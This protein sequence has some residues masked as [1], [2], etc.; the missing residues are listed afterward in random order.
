MAQNVRYEGFRSWRALVEHLEAQAEKEGDA[1]ARAQLLL[2]MGSL[3]EFR[4]GEPSEANRSYKEAYRADKQCFAALRGARRLL[5]LRGRIDEKLVQLFEIEFKAIKKAG[6]SA[7]GPDQQGAETNLEFGWVNLVAGADT[8]AI[9]AFKQA[10]YLAPQDP[11][12]QT[13][14]EELGDDIDAPGRVTELRTKSVTLEATDRRAAARATLRAA[15][16]AVRA[17][18]PA[19]Q[20][21]GD[22]LRAAALD[23]EDDTALLVLHARVLPEAPTPAQVEKLYREVIDRATDPATKGRLAHDLAYRMLAQVDDPGTAVPLHEVAFELAPDDERTFEFLLL[24]YKAR[25]E[26][27]RVRDISA[28][29]AAAAAEADAKAYYLSTGAI[30]LAKDMGETALAGALA[31][32]L[33]EIDHAHP[34]LAELTAAGVVA[35]K[36]TPIAAPPA[37]A[38]AAPAPTPVPVAAAPTPAPAPAPAV[39]A[40]THADPAPPADPPAAEEVLDLDLPAP[41]AA[42]ADEAAGLEATNADKALASWRKLLDVAP[43]SRTVLEGVRRVCRA[44]RRWNYLVDAFKKTV[45][46][47]PAGDV[48]ERV[49]LLFELADTYAEDMGQKPSAL[50]P[51]QQAVQLAPKNVD[52]IDRLLALFEA[53]NRPA[54]HVKLLVTKAEALDDPVSKVEVL[55]QVARLYQDKFR[56]VGEAIKAFQH[57]LEV[58]GTNDV[59]ITTLK[60][61]YE[62]RKD[63]ESYVNLAR[64]EIELTDD[65]LARLERTIALAGLA[66]EKIRKPEVCIGLWEQVRGYDPANTDA[67][68]ALVGLY[69]RGKDYAKLAD[70]LRLQVDSVTAPAARK[71]VLLKL[72]LLYGDKIPD[73]G[74][75]IA[76]WRQIME[77]DPSD[78]RAPEQIKKRYL[79]LHAWDDIEAFYAETGGRW[80][81]LIRLLEKDA[82]ASTLPKEEKVAVQMKMAT[83]WLDKLQKADRAAACYEEVLKLEPTHRAAAQALI[84]LYEQLKNAAALARVLEIELGH[85]EDPTE[86]YGTMVR[87]GGL[88]AETLQKALDAFAWYAKAFQL[89]PT[90]PEL[91]DAL[92]AVA[93]KANKVEELVKLYREALKGGRITDELGMR[94]RTARLIDEALGRPEEALKDWEEVLAGD[95]TNADAL[96]AIERLYTQM[97]RFQDL[98]AILEKRRS[99]AASAEEENQILVHIARVWEEALNNRDQAIAVYR[100]VLDARGDDPEILRALQRLYED[101]QKWA[102]LLDMVERQRLLAPAGSEEQRGLAFRVAQ[103]CQTRLSDLGRAVEGY[104]A[105]LEEDPNYQ[106]AVEALEPA[107]EDPEHRAEVAQLLAGLFEKRE[108]WENLVRVT[109][110]LV[111]VADSA[112]EKLGHLR[113]IAE[114]QVQRLAQPERA[115]ATHQRAVRLAPEDVQ[116]LA[117]LEQ[118]AT[119][120]DAWTVMVKLLVEVVEKVEEREVRLRLWLKVAGVRE[121]FLGDGAGAIAA[122]QKALEAESAA[123]E[124]LDALERLFEAAERHED[125]L[126]IYRRRVGVETDPAR[127]EHYFSQMAF[128]SDEILNRPEDAITCYRDILAFD[129]SNRKALR[130]LEALYRRLEKWAELAD[131]YGQLLEQAADAD[132]TVHLKLA[133]AELRH[134]Q[135]KEVDVAIDLYRDILVAD[136]RQAEA[137]RALENILRLPEFELTVART[138]EPVYREIQ[139]WPKL[140]ASLE[141]LV[142]HAGEAREK[143]ELLHQVAQLQEVPGDNPERALDAFV[144]ALHEDPA[145]EATLG[146]IERLARVLGQPGKLVEAIEAEVGHVEDLDLAVRLHAKAAETAERELSDLDRGVKH[147]RAV[148][149]KDPTNMPALISLERIYAA[150]EKYEDL[151]QVFLRK[152]EV[153]QDPA[154]VKEQFVQAGRIYEEILDRKDRAIAVYRQLHEYDGEDLPAIDKLIELYLAQQSWNDLLALYEKKS[155]LVQ[156]LEEKKRILLETGSVLRLEVK[157]RQRAIDT[158][159]RILELDPADLQAIAQ[160]DELYEEAEA[161]HELL[162]VLER[163]AD[164]ATDPNDVLAFRFRAGR[165]WEQKLTEVPKAIEFYRGILDASPDHVPSIEA[166]E[167]LMTSGKEPLAAAAVLGPLYESAGEWRKL[168]ATH[169]VEIAKAEDPFRQVELLHR[170]AELYERPDKLNE[171]ENAF[172]AF[173]KAFRID[174]MNEH[175]L[176]AVERLASMLDVWPRLAT[177]YDEGVT[178]AKE[179]EIKVALGL[180]AAR[181][182]EEEVGAP[183]QAI[184]RMRAV[185]EHDAENPTALRGLDR[186]YR[187]TSAWADLVGVLKREEG[188]AENEDEALLFK[189]DRGQVLQ[190]EL[191]DV[192]GSIEAYREILDINPQHS[193][194]RASLE[195]L[196]AEGAQ[197][198]EIAGIL[199]PIYQAGE[200]WERLAK[201]LEAKVDLYEEPGKKLEVIHRI[202]EI[203]ESRLGNIEGAF[204]WLGRGLQL[205]PEDDRTAEELD[206]LAPILPQGWEELARTYAQ[207]LT[208]VEAGD[209]KLRAGKKLAHISEEQIGDAERTQQVWEHLLE[210]DGSDPEVLSALDRIYQ[211]TMSWEK[212]SEVLRRRVEVESSQDEQ[213]ELLTRLG[214]LHLGDLGD[215]KGAEQ[216]FRRIIDKLGVAHLPALE[217]LEQIYG[218]TGEWPKLYAVYKKQID[219]VLGEA[220]QSEVYAKMAHL[221]ADALEQPQEAVKLWQK[222][223]DI[224]GEE[225]EPLRAL[226]TLHEQ[227]E[228]WQELDAT[229]ERLVNIAAED[230]ERAALYVKIGEIRHDRLNKGS[231]A[232]DAY[233]Q[234]LDIDPNNL[235]ALRRKAAI[236]AERE[237]W[238]DLIETLQ[239]LVDVGAGQLDAEELTEIHAQMGTVFADK[240]ERTFEAIESWRHVLEVAPREPRALDRLEA[241]LKKEERWQEVVEVLE[242][243]VELLAEPADQVALW[244]EVADLWKEKIGERGGSAAGLEA[245]LALQP[246]DEAT[247]TELEAVYGDYERWD[248][249]VAIYGRK[250]QQLEGNSKLRAIVLTKIGRIYLD[251]KH[252]ETSAYGVYKAAYL[253]DFNN[254]EIAQDLERVANAANGW[255][256]LL[257]TLSAKIQELGPTRPAI[258]L[259]LAVGRWYARQL[260]RLDFAVQIY[261]TVL[262]K[263]DPAN[264]DALLFLADAYRDMKQWP[265]L[266]QTLNRCIEVVDDPQRKKNILVQLGQTQEEV[267]GEEREAMM[268]YR[269]A[270]DIDADLPAALEAL[271]R[272]YRKAERWEDLVPILERRIGIEQDG[273]QIVALKLQV[274]ELFE[275]RLQ[276]DEL[277]I[278]AYRDVLDREASNERALKGLERLYAR[279]ERWQDLLD[280]LEIEH[281]VAESERERLTLLERMASMLEEEFLRHEDAAK[282]LEQVLE[283]DPTSENGL[284]GLER[285]YRQLQRWDQLAETYGRHVEAAVERSLKVQH[286]KSQATV[287]LENLNDPDRAIEAL[288]HVLDLDPDEPEALDRLATLL[289]QRS[290]ASGSL[291]MLER[292]AA[293]VTTDP[294]RQVDILTRVGTVLEKQLSDR[295]GAIARFEQALAIVPEHLPALAALREIYVDNQEWVLAARMLDREQAAT[296][297]ER[298]RS[299]LLTQRGKILLE[300]LENEG[301]AITCFEA[302]LQL[303]P[304]ADEAGEP[305]V[306]IY[307]RDQQYAKAEPVLDMLL[308]RYQGKRT[309]QELRPLHMELAE[310]AEAL[311]NT[312]KALKSLRVA[313]QGDPSDLECIRRTANVHYKRKEWDGSFKFY[314]MIL[315]QHIDKLVNEEKVEIYY[316][317]GNIKMAVKEVRKALNMYEKALDL[318]ANHRPTL[319]ALV[320]LFQSQRDFEQVIHFKKQIA[321]TAAD[322]EKFKL[323]DEVGDIWREKQ[324]NTH[325]AIQSYVDALAVKAD[326]RIVLVKLLKLY[327][328]TKQWPKAIEVCLRVVQ[329]ETEPK[330][331]AAYYQLI[332]TTYRDEIKD[333]DK[334]VEFFDKALDADSDNLKNFEAIEK[335]LTPKRDW[336]SLERAYRRMVKRLPETGKEMLKENLLH[337]LGEIARSRL[338]NLEL[339]A[340]CFKLASEIN[341]DNRIRHEILA[342]LFVMMPGRW[343]DAVH[344]HQVLLRQDPKRVES[345]RALR[346]IYQDAGKADETWCLC[347]ALSFLGKAEANEKQFFEQYRPK[348]PPAIRGAIGNE[349]WYKNLYHHEENIYVSKIFEA[350]TPS[351]RQGMVTTTKAFG[352]RK[353]DLQDPATSQLALAKSLRDA[354]MGLNLPLPELYVVPE[355]PGGLTFAFTEPPASVAGA[356]FLTGYSP[357][358]LRFVAAKH[359]SSY[360][361]EHYLQYLLHTTAGQ[362][363]VSLTQVLLMYLYAAVKLGVP[364]AAVPTNDAVMQVAGHLQGK[365]G[366]QDREML[367]AAARRF[368]E[369]PVKNIKPWMIAADLTGD[370]A[371]LL[372]CGDLPTAAKMMTKIPS[373]VT[374][375]TPTQRITELTV[376]AVSD[377][378]FRIRK[379]LGIALGTG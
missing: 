301:E 222:V 194:T 217:G 325:K 304:E 21:R 128:I 11:D 77:L 20:V 83:L 356:D 5:R 200:E 94:Q 141:I 207:I 154:E 249:L 332:A 165:I 363:Q 234:V 171:P 243:R 17:G 349:S 126:D 303:D 327:T 277:A 318:D 74:S 220:A 119:V 49:Q 26:K 361:R 312:E 371:G 31:A 61:I 202:A 227:L 46:R 19:D 102:E 299:K 148:L 247:F 169:E 287:L 358:E 329:Q 120:L 281:G 235:D 90:Q 343:E 348:S 86:R 204:G 336:K 269:K 33:A 311:D 246:D 55:L 256:D 359:L 198:M 35:E 294:L 62:A 73:D 316:R 377:A 293:V 92:E 297:G 71:D 107:L 273:A 2:R 340:E 123:V 118:L 85:L 267:L 125:L 331:L 112:D 350:V 114:I 140:I 313:Y 10:A 150:T 364:D 291:E 187:G 41:H 307:M 130:A 16:L 161:W 111:E 184:Q 75:S 229:L 345:Y 275:D 295:G 166:L 355:Q 67:L 109:E 242:Q 226:A 283:I 48:S 270:L 310:A 152:A 302:A 51:L 314:Q 309:A 319:D 80:D 97:G 37:P 259:Y 101:A 139:D 274:A 98:L 153:V 44:T 215:M 369:A 201:L 254:L 288:R 224:R 168:I 106:P 117:D 122:Y 338:K 210:V 57:V 263:I 129:S 372:L 240:L 370:R 337:N 376:F 65:P 137:I 8:K 373:L 43:P 253:E 47:L 15:L 45:D 199:E 223:L 133:L 42:A 271:D 232:L 134:V 225:T 24:L 236:F 124:A 136:P 289:D 87:I 354:A 14:L 258:P 158:Y 172:N 18:V 181:V 64:R 262:G 284:S 76:I 144:R 1:A 183:P 68:T 353:K 212:L 193:A 333:T 3:R 108:D 132:E 100:Q 192:G 321:E 286:L 344:E 245:I 298:L 190:Q 79:A 320:E 257:A 379:E 163:E 219:A 177:L 151:A 305:L 213:I 146:N 189:F 352:L 131:V 296:P 196:Y 306:A 60:E 156:D 231:D 160:L 317:L 39:S 328:E 315:V 264:A 105:I 221:A 322:D 175:T 36:V 52:A 360:R 214:R 155:D 162:V 266:V 59:A 228:Q 195:L 143:V 69:E 244:R 25:G 81:E 104:R 366:G 138:L 66:T 50:Q 335:I 218:Q 368:L 27:Q 203:Y 186:L 248:E 347:A 12:I 29:A 276:K 351:V 180:R 280:I 216:A 230:Q 346:R 176:E 89:D 30:V 82:G 13:L 188:I 260:K 95:A 341:P 34:A 78:R 342:E 22:L 197:Q 164:V 110:V 367:Q 4:L 237:S 7:D 32:L 116:A 308:R 70:V 323:L 63:W 159:K 174:P 115:F 170:V 93:G 103:I 179:P 292:L 9:S 40:P 54:D 278:K 326:D 157:D 167:S 145:D 173:A 142:K 241:L 205:A 53:L 56:N 99:I 362:M 127:K 91:C 149:A 339:A 378:H 147:H 251:K 250:Y 365:M 334:A 268:S 135:V 96:I 23:P 191:K 252:D 374:D 357:M 261:A 330:R 300:H 375:L 239:R 88:F 209:I 38:P 121:N 182:Y 178:S 211:V 279:G 324:N 58:D 272:L 206:R 265:A 290:D 72:G 282:R 6:R 84:P 255:E 285:L 238:E 113:R 208:T 28:R 185:L 233:Q